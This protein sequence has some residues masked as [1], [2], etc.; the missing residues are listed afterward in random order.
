LFDGFLN[1][2]QTRIVAAK[3]IFHFTVFILFLNFITAPYRALIISRENI[4]FLSVID[5]IDGILKIVIALLLPKLT[6]DYLAAYGLLLC[7]IYIFNFGALASYGMRNYT[8]CILPKLSYFN[9]KTI[10]SLASFA[11]WTV[12]SIGCIIIRTQGVAV[13]LNLYFGPIVNAAF[14]LALQIG[15]SLNFLSQSIRNAFNPQIM[16]KE[17][18]GRRN[19]MLRLSEI[20]SKF[21]MFLLAAIVVPL[22]IE[23]P[24]LLEL[25]LN[26]V[27]ENTIFFCRM[28]LIATLIDQTTIGLGSANQAIG[29]IRRYSLIVN[30]VKVITIPA[31]WIF[32]KMSLN[33]NIIYLSFLFFEILSAIL[34]L[35][36]LNRTGDLSIIGYLTRVIMKGIA[37][38]AI[39]I[40][41]SIVIKENMEISFRFIFTF[42]ISIIVYSFAIYFF[43]LCNDEKN[44][45]KDFGNKLLLKFK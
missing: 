28:I 38:I 15:G 21:S 5:V 42:S 29:N 23:L 36:V 25:W 13:I 31:I 24:I 37:P 7:G 8:E 1:I 2:P 39:I 12:Y 3:Q 11:G 16:K 41:T 18:E 35:L 43:G 27:P 22:I 44:F 4:V 10:K 6:I 34:R 32:L 9:K 17:G 14:G 19:Q 30:T 40:I 33:L 20:A 45:V 26:E